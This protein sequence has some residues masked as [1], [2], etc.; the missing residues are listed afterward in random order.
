MGA[1]VG[2][3]KLQI[4][5]LV[6]RQGAA[7]LWALSAE[8]CAAMAVHE[9]NTAGGILRREVE[10][11]VRDAGPSADSAADAAAELV[12]LDE[13]D[14]LVGMFP[15]YARRS[16]MASI[17][18]KVPFI[19][20]PQF[21]GWEVSNR[22]VTTGETSR[23]LLEPAIFWLMQEKRVQR[24]YLCG[25]N[26]IWPRS[27]FAMAKA[28]IKSG[29]GTVVGE[30]YLNVDD[31][32]YTSML[33]H[34]K[35]S[36][37]HAVLPHF[38]G[39]NSIEFNRE[40]VAAGLAPKML[41]FASNVDETIVYGL[42]ENATENLFVS[43]A[44][45]SSVKSL[46]NASFLERYHSFYGEAPPPVN[47]YGESCYEGVYSCA[48]LATSSGAIDHT[49]FVSSLGSVRQTITARGGDR[50]PM[51]G[52]RHPIYFADVDGLDIRILSAFGT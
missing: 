50:M 1:E 17:G 40:F 44:Y 39:S 5:L 18:G 22:V 24:F 51:V 37:A 4:G 20:T 2:M 31:H 10:L 45:F 9:I 14:M 36:G 16:V 6:P 32:D 48:A 33:S 29:G 41:R 13:A 47:A 38:L 25:S 52:T 43:S 26:Y 34:I 49:L 23:E 42:G 3:S 7:G 27:L 8:A 30:E 19:Y 35:H 15:S 11:S 28:L 46:N 12:E 21:E